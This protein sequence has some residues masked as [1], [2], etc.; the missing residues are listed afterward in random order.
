MPGTLGMGYP[1]TMERPRP[2]RDFDFADRGALQVAIY[3][4]EVFLDRYPH[5]VERLGLG[6]TLRPASRQAGHRMA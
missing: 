4:L 5:V 2:G 3:G 6:A 1:E